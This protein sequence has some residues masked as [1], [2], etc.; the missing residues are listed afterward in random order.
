[1]FKEIIM[2]SHRGFCG[3][4]AGLEHYGETSGVDGGKVGI[5]EKT[6]ELSLGCLL[7]SE[8]S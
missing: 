3:R 7:K 2:L 4:G 8:E 1:M 6:D 5:F